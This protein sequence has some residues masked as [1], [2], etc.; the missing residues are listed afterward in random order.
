MSDAQDGGASGLDAALG[1]NRGAL[2]IALDVMLPARGVTAL[3][4]PSGAG[5]TSCLRMIAGLDRMAA[6]RL[7]VADEIWQ[8]SNRG[9]FLPPHRR[10][11]GYVT[12][13]PALFAHLDVSGNLDFGHR[14][15]GRPASLDRED[16][17]AAGLAAELPLPV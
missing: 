12:Q 5:K 15:A 13:E 3:F 10:R 8:D 17:I 14:R 6:G 2:S 11:V 1:W 4:G 9:V 16:L 7:R